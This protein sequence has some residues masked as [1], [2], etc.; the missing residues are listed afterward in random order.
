MLY[1]RSI[2][3]SKIVSINVAENCVVAK[4]TTSLKKLQIAP[5]NQQRYAMQK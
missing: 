2:N 5:I 1:V 4:K 3:I